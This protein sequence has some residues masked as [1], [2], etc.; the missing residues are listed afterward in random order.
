MRLIFFAFAGDLAL[1]L[2]SEF[3]GML[4]FFKHFGSATS[5]THDYRSVAQDSS[6][7]GLVD[8]DALD[9]GEEDFRGAAIHEAGFYDDSLVGD[10]H[11]RD[12]A[13]Q[14]TD[15]KEGRSDE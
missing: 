12:T 3:Q 1:D 4:D 2:F 10:G 6:H 5:A 15:A 11:L 13:L 9:S 7:G 14:Q 8:H